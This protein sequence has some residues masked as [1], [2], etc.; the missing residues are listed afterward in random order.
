M[1]VYAKCNL[2]SASSPPPPPLVSL[3]TPQLPL[4]MPSQLSSNLH[5]ET[6]FNTAAGRLW[7][8]STHGGIGYDVVSRQTQSLELGNI[9]QIVVVPARPPRAP[10]HKMSAA[11]P[12]SHHVP[13]TVHSE[14]VS[15]R[16]AVGFRDKQMPSLVRCNGEGP[17]PVPRDNSVRPL[18]TAVLLHDLSGQGA[19]L[20]RTQRA[21]ERPHK[22]YRRE[23][24]KS[25]ATNSGQRM[26]SK[27]STIV[28]AIHVPCPNVKC[29]T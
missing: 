12:L 2:T 20:I 11:L 10:R 6:C 23:G 19:A 8:G 27:L 25:N 24:G 7:A 29:Y 17:H 13:Q 16:A 1:V 15:R 3:P 28:L 21:N 18:L 14:S 5:T 22:R 26:L 4:P 9:T